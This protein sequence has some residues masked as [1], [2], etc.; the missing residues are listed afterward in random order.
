MPGPGVKRLAKTEHQRETGAEPRGP[1][2]LRGKERPKT[3]RE[4]A[5][6]RGETQ[7]PPP[8]KPGGAKERRQATTP[9]TGPAEKGPAKRQR[10]ET[11]RTAESLG[12]SPAG[13]KPRVL[14][15]SQTGEHAQ[16]APN[17]SL[18][19]EN[20]GGKARAANHKTRDV[21]PSSQGGKPAPR[22]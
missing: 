15:H 6:E 7:K 9:P 1:E 12:K 20:P 13:K 10:G 22:V 16:A 3:V 8:P 5:L 17:G 2:P 21:G 18:G 19:E 4:L 11:V 14:A